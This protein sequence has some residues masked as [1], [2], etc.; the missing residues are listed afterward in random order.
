MTPWMWM[1]FENQRVF[2]THRAAGWGEA[3]QQPQG[4]LPPGVRPADNYTSPVKM[5]NLTVMNTY[6]VNEFIRYSQD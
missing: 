6:Y 2:Y 1:H 5:V 4:S 3:D